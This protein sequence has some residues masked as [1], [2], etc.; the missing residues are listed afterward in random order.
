MPPTK[1]PTRQRQRTY[2]REW[3]EHLGLTQDDAQEL[4]GWSQSKISR[5]ENG[6][7]P[8][9]QDELEEAAEKYGCLPGELLMVNPKDPD[10][11]M[12]L[13]SRAARADKD[14][15]AQIASYL[16]FTLRDS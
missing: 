10:E 9:S 8:Y 3:R 4:L 7:T 5:I 2:F 6:V 1:K 11:F 13:L 16:K 15:Q 14:K 12:G